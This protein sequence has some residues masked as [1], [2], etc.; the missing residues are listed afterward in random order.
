MGNEA[1]GQRG[2]GRAETW[3]QRLG[4]RRGELSIVCV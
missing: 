3:E 2:Q 4:C 1:H